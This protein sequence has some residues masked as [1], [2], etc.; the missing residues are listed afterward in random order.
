MFALFRVCVQHRREERC[1]RSAIRENKP[2]PG[3]KYYVE[4]IRVTRGRFNN[5]SGVEYSEC[6]W[7]AT[8]VVGNRTEK[9]SRRTTG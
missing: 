8:G 5:S 6:W 3:E 1:L 2:S 9:P 4:G 7:S